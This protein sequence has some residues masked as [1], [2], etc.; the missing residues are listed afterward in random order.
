MSN[1]ARL[2]DAFQLL[3]ADLLSSLGAGQ[4]STFTSDT[5]DKVTYNTCTIQLDV[6]SASKT[7]TVEIQGSLDGTNWFAIPYRTPSSDTSA[8]TDLTIATTG[9][10]VYYLDPKYVRYVRV[11]VSA[12]TGVVFNSIKA[13][14]VF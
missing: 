3:Q 6:T 7:S 14:A 12:N 9:I 8:D 10:Y 5:L 2:H 1:G 11:D 4:S 13:W